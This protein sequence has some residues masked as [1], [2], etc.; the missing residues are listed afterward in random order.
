V[1][2]TAQGRDIERKGIEDDEGRIKDQETEVREGEVGLCSRD[3]FPKVRFA[4][5]HEQPSLHFTFIQ[6]H[7]PFLHNVRSRYVLVIPL[8]CNIHT[9]SLITGQ[10]PQLSKEEIKVTRAAFSPLLF[11]I[12]T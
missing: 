5:R 4:F 6:P 2:E 11:I 7:I 9:D 3:F 8:C 12:N 10:E 1:Q